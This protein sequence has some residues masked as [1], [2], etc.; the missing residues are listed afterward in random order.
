[1]WFEVSAGSVNVGRLRVGR[2]VVQGK[3]SAVE[4]SAVLLPAVGVHPS[5]GFS[6]AVL[7]AGV[8]LVRLSAAVL[9]G[10]AVRV[11]F[12]AAVK[13]RVERVERSSKRT[14]PFSAGVVR[15]ASRVRWVWRAVRLVR[16]KRAV[17]PGLRLI[18]WDELYVAIRY[19][20]AFKM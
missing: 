8:R 19:G 20:P 12:S 14:V 18:L 3:V 7:S 9:A 1:L 5:V 2:F 4:V 6:A 11:G 10:A 16:L 17:R 13:L 15:S